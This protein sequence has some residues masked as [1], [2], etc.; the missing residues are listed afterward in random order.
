MEKYVIKLEAGYFRDYV[1][2][3]LVYEESTIIIY[4]KV[5]YHMLTMKMY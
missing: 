2:T 1:E 4:L 5:L 3:R